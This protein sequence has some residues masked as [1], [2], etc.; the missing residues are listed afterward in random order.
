VAKQKELKV[1]ERFRGK[2]I[3]EIVKLSNGWYIVKTENSKSLKDFKVK[4]IFSLQPLRSITPKHAH[5]AIDFYG[6]LCSN[7]E[8]AMKVFNAIIEVWNNRPPEEVLRKYKEQVK[9]LPGYDLE[10]IL[11]ALKW[12][13]E[14]EDINFVGR[15]ENK[16]KQISEILQKQG[17]ITPEGRKGSELAISLFC[18]I[19][20]GTHPVEA[21]MKANL[22][23]LPRKRR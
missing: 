3:K 23:V 5:F 11:Y 13:L 2:E 18:D 16:Q 21:F 20:N 15:P 17:V 12:I 6:K 7:K 22:D 10:Y 4:T 9:G 14:Q 19:A 1:G 8:K